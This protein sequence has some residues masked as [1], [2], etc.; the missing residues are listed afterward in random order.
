[1]SKRLV[2]LDESIIKVTL[3]VDG[4]DSEPDQFV[5][6]GKGLLGVWKK[7]LD[8][9]T[10]IGLVG[11]DSTIS[12]SNNWTRS[13]VNVDVGKVQSQEPV[14]FSFDGVGYSIS[15]TRILQIQESE[16][17]TFTTL[18][19]RSGGRINHVRVDNYS[20]KEDF[21]ET[22]RVGLSSGDPFNFTIGCK[23]SRLEGILSSLD[24][25]V[26]STNNQGVEWKLVRGEFGTPV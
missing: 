19:Y 4:L 1:M 21:H 23:L 2:P 24:G 25:L 12:S 11:P 20:S 22:V 8:V 10:S 14:S 18:Q 3:T 17:T 7:I 5:F 26:N 15:A 6:R 16:P 9:T 13:D